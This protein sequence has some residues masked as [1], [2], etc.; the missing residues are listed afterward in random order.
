MFPNGQV[1]ILNNGNSYNATLVK[2]DTGKHY[3]VGLNYS[4]YEVDMLDSQAKY[5][6]MRKKSDMEKQDD[7]IKAPM[8][9][10]IVKIYVEPGQQ[11]QPG[12]IVLTIEAM[13]MQSSISVT[14]ACTVSEIKC[15]ANDSVMA[16]QILVTL[17]INKE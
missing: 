8:P 4:N 13:K 10:K 6:R 1:S 5:M 12:D 15:A 9:C 3:R 14:E 11:L 7:K 2:S 16:D 17:N